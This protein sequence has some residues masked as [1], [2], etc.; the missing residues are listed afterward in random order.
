MEAHIGAEEGHNEA[1]E[2]VL[3]SRKI[4]LSAPKPGSRRSEFRLRLQL[5]PWI[6]LQDTLKITF[7]DLSNSIKI[8]TIFKNLS[9]N[10]D[11][12][13]KISPRLSES[14]LELESQFV[15]IRLRLRQAI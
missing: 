8:V 4:F 1:L 6:V 11:F 14:E 12:L 15:K 13:N 2:A 10:H 5:R 7:F 9:S 3:W